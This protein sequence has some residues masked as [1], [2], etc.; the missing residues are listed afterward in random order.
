MVAL[1]WTYFS[2]EGTFWLAVNIMFSAGS[3]DGAFSNP[4]EFD[5]Y[6]SVVASDGLKNGMFICVELSGLRI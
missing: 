5:G 2:S 4:A 1:S 6:M 3:Y